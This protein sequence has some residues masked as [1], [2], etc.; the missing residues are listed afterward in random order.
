[1]STQI[2]DRSEPDRPKRKKPMGFWSTICLALFIV[3]G[4]PTLAIHVSFGPVL[5]YSPPIRGRVID[6]STGQPL[7]DAVVVGLW[8]ADGRTYGTIHASETITG[9]DGS[10]ELPGMSLR[11]RPL[12]RYF[13]FR[14]PELW[15]YKPG[16][17]PAR[18]NNAELGE[19]GWRSGRQPWTMHPRLR[20]YWDGKTVPLRRAES[21]TSQVEAFAWVR[22]SVIHSS[23]K[24]LSPREFPLVWA[25]VVEGARRVPRSAYTDKYPDPRVS[26]DSLM[27]KSK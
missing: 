24:P 8:I 27:R 25:A 5:I 16:Y 12:W 11:F 4:V 15:I 26:Y 22:S 3:V 9:R 6:E 17:W 21:V 14:D 1:M 2:F 7:S 13:K 18:L 23:H 19:F 20:C 10:Y